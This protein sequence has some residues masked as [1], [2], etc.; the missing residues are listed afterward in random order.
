MKQLDFWRKKVRDTQ[1][2]KFPHT[3]PPPTDLGGLRPIPNPSGKSK[4]ES[5]NVEALERL[6][7]KNITSKS[8]EPNLQ[9]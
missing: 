4:S 6:E 8:V 3:P 1:T 7:L 9:F 5:S 2:Q